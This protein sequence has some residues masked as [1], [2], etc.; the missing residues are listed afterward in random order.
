[1][2]LLQTIKYPD[3]LLWQRA[4]EITLFDGDLKVFADDLLETMY[5][6]SG[7]G[8]TA[9]HIGVL[10]RLVVIDLEKGKP[11]IY[12]N[13]KIIWSSPDNSKAMEGSVSMPGVT[14]EIERPS[15]I[16]MTYQDL[17]GQYQE[18]EANGFLATCLQHE[19]DQ[20]N[21]IFWLDRLSRL[22]RER[23]IK[24]YKKLQ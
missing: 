19:V 20:L 24:R 14:E 4:A 3:A 18:I 13:P 21:G 6:A 17:S 9:C 11:Q 8:I 22:K 15:R 5:A 23:V 10:K 7:I 16:K 1:M 2:T 12:V